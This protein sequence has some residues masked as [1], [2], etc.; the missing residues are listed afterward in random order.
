MIPQR[1]GGAP[2]V[3]MATAEAL[4]FEYGCF[5]A[6]MAIFTVHHWSDPALGLAEMRRVARRQVVLTV[7]PAV[8][9]RFWL[10]ADYLPAAAELEAARTI[11]LREI[12]GCLGATRIEAGPAPADCID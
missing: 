12:A 3:V 10:L 8:H 11:P 7:D 2:P 5:D 6:A 4:P 1:P 9:D